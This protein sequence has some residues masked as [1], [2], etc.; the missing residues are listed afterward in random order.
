MR[1]KDVPFCVFRYGSVADKVFIP[2]RGPLAFGLSIAQL[3]PECGGEPLEMG[4]TDISEIEGEYFRF[5][6]DSVEA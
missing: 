2:L 3:K 5:Y 1:N 6:F 4:K